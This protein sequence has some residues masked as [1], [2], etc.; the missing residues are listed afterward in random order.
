MYSYKHNK[1]Y[2]TCDTPKGSTKLVACDPGEI[3]SKSQ[4][5]VWF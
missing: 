2:I 5:C 3:T 1:E 4:R